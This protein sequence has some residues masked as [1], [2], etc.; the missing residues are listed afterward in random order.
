[1]ACVF[2]FVGIQVFTRFLGIMRVTGGM[3]LVRVPIREKEK[4]FDEQKR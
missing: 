3:A 2:V 4:E 1:M